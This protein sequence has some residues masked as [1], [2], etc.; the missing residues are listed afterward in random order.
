[1]KKKRVSETQ[2]PTSGLA[3]IYVRVSSKEQEREGFSIPAQKRLLDEYAEAQGLKIVEVFEEAETAKQTGRKEFERMLRLIEKSPQIRHIL[4]EKTDRLYRNIT[5][6]G[7]LDVKRLGI[8][9]H[10]VK[11][12]TIIS[13]ESKS[14][15]NFM[16]GIQVLMAKQYVD[17]LSE[18]V[19]KGQHEKARQ[20]H[21]PGFAPIGYKNNL[22]ERRIVP[23][24]KVAPLI[25]KAFELASTGLYSLAKLKRAL[26]HMGLRSKRGR[27]ELSKSAMVIVLRNRLY[28]GEFIWGGKVYQSKDEPLVTRALFESAQVAMGFVQKPRISKHDFTYT[29]LMTCAHCGCAI[30][31]ERQRKKSGKTYV[32]YHCTN[33]KGS[34]E[35]VTYLREERIEDEFLAALRAIKLSPEILNWTR[36]ALLESAKDEA[37]FRKEQMSNLTARFQKLDSFI[38]LSYVDRLEGR[39]EPAEWERK[40]ESWKREQSEIEERLRA[41]REANTGYMQDGIRLMERASKAAE[42]FPLL[43]PGEKREMVSLILSNPRIMRGNL[44]IS[45]QMPF[46]AFTNV[47]DLD[48]MRS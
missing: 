19:R 25:V 26:Y 32:Y 11:D 45:Y 13:Q 34:C 16:H 37:L 17:N 12:N 42:T 39:L 6:Y 36:D 14:S 30:T 1:M 5:D 20:G 10:L 7:R 24:P 21:W 44:V 29:G 33:G 48:E 28:C 9:I 46:S 38:E 43:T 47:G 35:N 31:A 41:F 4:V 3:V 15:E 18:E 40:T 27:N 23:D 22:E 8:A 2:G